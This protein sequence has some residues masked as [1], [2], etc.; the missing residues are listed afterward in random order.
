MT[1]E[2]LTRVF[3]GISQELLALDQRDEQLASKLADVTA[4]L[5]Q[6]D[7][8]LAQRVARLESAIENWSIL[9]G[10]DPQPKRS[11]LLSRLFIRG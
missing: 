9:A 4:A 6:A 3:S 10:A 2:Q 1:E 5:V 8:A 11:G 7:G